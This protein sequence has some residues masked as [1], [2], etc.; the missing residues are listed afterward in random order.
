LTFAVSITA[1]HPASSASVSVTLD[2]GDDTHVSFFGA[3]SPDVAIY[4]F[5]TQHVY[6]R[7]T[8]T[9]SVVA[10]DTTG[11]KARASQVVV[12]Q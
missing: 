12:V 8:Y 11:Q 2:F 7:G 4:S 1:I 3:D 9:A 10:M 5:L 6:P